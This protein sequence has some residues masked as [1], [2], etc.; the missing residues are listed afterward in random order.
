[1]AEKKEEINGFNEEQAIK[2]LICVDTEKILGILEDKGEVFELMTK[3]GNTKVRVTEKIRHFCHLVIYSRLNP[4]GIMPENDKKKISQASIEVF[5]VLYPLWEPDGATE[6]LEDIICNILHNNPE[7]SC[8]SKK[9]VDEF[10]SEWDN[11]NS[12]KKIMKNIFARLLAK[13]DQ[14]V[15]EKSDEE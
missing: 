10:L 13:E 8:F 1:M 14:K 4:E 2:S 11:R 15:A 12:R 6:A 9:E 5:S 3:I 7:D